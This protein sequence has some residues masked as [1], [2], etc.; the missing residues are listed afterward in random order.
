[1]NKKGPTVKVGD[2]V[3]LNNLGLRQIYGTTVGLSSM[4]NKIMTITWVSPESMTE[5]E[6]TYPV[7][8]DDPE[9]NRFLIDDIC[10]DK[11]R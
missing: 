3:C 1:M 6:E 4:R 9:I 7:D 11:Q 2:K 10:F 8:V 5:P